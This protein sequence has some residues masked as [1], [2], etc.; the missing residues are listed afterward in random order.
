MLGRRSRLV[1]GILPP[2]CRSRTSLCAKVIACPSENS[3]YFTVNNRVSAKQTAAFCFKN[4]GGSGVSIVSWTAGPRVVDFL[5]RACKSF[6]VKTTGR[7]SVAMVSGI[8]LGRG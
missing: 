3:G 8:A 4:L 1:R 2:S 7:F 5:Q 6:A